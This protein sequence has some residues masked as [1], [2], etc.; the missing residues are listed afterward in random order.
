[1]PARSVAFLYFMNVR[2]L[3]GDIDIYLFD[4]IQKNRFAPD[5]RILDAGCGG[6]RNLVYFLRMGYQVFGID[7]SEQAIE[8]MS[9]LAQMIVPDFPTDNFQVS[10]IEKTPFASGAFDVV[11]S[12]AVLHFATDET[13]FNQ[14][15]DEM[16]RV[17]CPNGILF[18]RLASDIGI[19][20]RV[21]LIDGRR[22][23]LPDGS[24]RFL[25]DEKMLIDKTNQVGGTFIEPIK[26]TNV[27][28]LRCMT[29]W[30][31]RK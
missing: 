12:S 21:K 31:L 24:E 14:M 17:L 15:F 11:I 2:E 25:V 20:N 27:Q 1:M 18:A 13:H 4:Q 19:E 28:N 5:S 9:S 7:Q 30:V 8:D 16:W 29:T 3:F 10:T 23:L 6:G 22:F 26:T